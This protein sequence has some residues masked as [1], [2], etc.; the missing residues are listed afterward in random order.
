ME[1]FI[2]RLPDGTIQIVEAE[3]ADAARS[4]LGINLGERFLILSPFDPQAGVLFTNEELESVGLGRPAARAP[5]IIGTQFLSPSARG[6][7]NLPNRFLFGLSTILGVQGFEEELRPELLQRQF[8]AP[9][10]TIRSVLEALVPEGDASAGLREFL[11]EWFKE[12]SYANPLDVLDDELFHTANARRVD[13]DFRT[14][15]FIDAQ[16]SGDVQAQI[17]AQVALTVAQANIDPNSPE[18]R[19]ILAAQAR[20]DAAVDTLEPTRA[21]TKDAAWN[22]LVGVLNVQENLQISAITKYLDEHRAE[23]ES[24]FESQ[25]EFDDLIQFFNSTF[26]ASLRIAIEAEL[27][28]QTDRQSFDPVF[29]PLISRVLQGLPPAFAADARQALLSALADRRGLTGIKDKGILWFGDPERG[30]D[31]FDLATVMDSFLAEQLPDEVVQA[32][33]Q[34]QFSLWDVARGIAPTGFLEQGVDLATPDSISAI[35]ANIQQIA[36]GLAPELFV[37]PRDDPEFS[38]RA[39][40]R[41]TFAPVM[42]QLPAYLRGGVI[43]EA[44]GTALENFGRDFDFTDTQAIV[45]FFDTPGDGVDQLEDFTEQFVRNDIIRAF[46]SDID[47]S[48]NLLRVLDD[49]ADRNKITFLD[50]FKQELQINSDIR[51]RNLYDLNLFNSSEKFPAPET[52][53]AGTIQLQEILDRELAGVP[54]FLRPSIQDFALRA[55]NRAQALNPDLAREDIVTSA[56]FT[57]SIRT[58]VES[59]VESVF[60]QSDL[61]RALIAGFG[62]GRAFFSTF[63]EFNDAANVAQII[64]Q[65]ELNPERFI[66]AAPEGFDPTRVE[67]IIA[68]GEEEAEERGVEEALSDFA[69]EQA[70]ERAAFEFP[71]AEEF[72]GAARRFLTPGVAAAVIQDVGGFALSE[73]QRQ[74]ERARGFVE[75]GGIPAEALPF[76]GFDPTF[77]FPPELEQL[78]GETP[79]E[80]AARTAEAQ[81]AQTLEGGRAAAA[82]FI[83]SE[84]LGRGVSPADFF[85]QQKRISL[86]ARQQFRVPT[87]RRQLPRLRGGR[88]LGIS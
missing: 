14:Q 49:S 5:E 64:E 71:F 55:E 25:T 18:A 58:F 22:F 41:Q 11:V 86:T 85:Q 39:F 84:T 32:F 44:L 20:T 30:L 75:R 6:V 8:G 56:E 70:L 26:G 78:E 34:A 79:E 3:S 21:R 16:E 9:P 87:A 12:N 13:L 36:L 61:A 74:V 47:A 72:A 82:S 37:P 43:D 53:F 69:R 80:F 63:D 60:A 35:F 38:Q 42:N 66:A 33:A 51:F 68:A 77:L 83:R 29:G 40:I 17:N 4:Q 88:S 48:T 24:A 54:A 15:A 27:P 62:G 59:Q 76:L 1:P 2:V 57:T 10:E 19:S 23:I 45:R 7:V 52:P 65:I 81:T 31:P 50:A 46:G 28:V 67:T 73:F